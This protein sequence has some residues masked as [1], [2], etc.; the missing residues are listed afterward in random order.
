VLEPAQ[1]RRVGRV[2]EIS[3]QVE[4]PFARLLEG[5]QQSAKPFLRRPRGFDIG[6]ANRG[7]EQFRGCLA[8]RGGARGDRRRSG[9]LD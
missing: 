3:E 8:G 2:A 9:V 1:G 6:R 5:R 7:V 4:P